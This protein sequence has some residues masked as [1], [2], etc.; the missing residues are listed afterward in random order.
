VFTKNRWWIHLLGLFAIGAAGVLFLGVQTYREAPPVA[1]FAAPDGEVLASAGRIREGQA[2]FQRYAL[3]EHGTMFGD[4]GCRGP[5]YSAEALHVS[6]LAMLEHHRAAAGGEAGEADVD[7]EEVLLA[8]VQGEIAANRHD[9]RTGTV[10]LAPSQVAAYEAVLESTR[11]KFAADGPE[12][13]R[14][15]AY[16]TDED[17]LAALGTFFFWSGW[18]C[19]TTRPGTDASYTQNWPY[20]PLVGNGPTSGAVL[21]SVVGSLAMLLATGVVLYR[22]GRPERSRRSAPGDVERLSTDVEVEREAPTAIQRAT[23]KYFAVAAAL[24]GLQVLSGILTVHDYVGFTTF[25]GHDLARALPITVVRS[26][27]V[28]LSILWIATCWIGGSIFLLPRISRREPKGQRACVEILFWMLVAVVAGTLFGTLAGP[29]GWLGESWRSLGHQGWEFV[30]LGRLWQVLLFAALV[31]WAVIV[32]RGVRPALRA[33]QPFSLPAWMLYSVAAI[34]ALFLS[35][36]VAPRDASFVVADFWRWMVIHMWAECFFEVFTTVIVA[37]FLVHMGLVG[38]EAATRVVFFAVLLFCGSG[39]LGISHNFYWNAKPE[40]TLAIGAV[41][42]TL[43][44]VPLI[45]LTLET[46]RL[47]RLPQEAMRELTDGGRSRFGHQAA[48]RFLVAVNFW[49]FLGAGVFGFIINL[50]IVNYYEHGTYLTVNHGHAALM[51]VYGNLSIAAILFCARWLVEPARWN[52]ALLTVAFWS[53]NAGLG[54]M[55]ALDLL[56]AGMLQL[57]AVLERGLWFARSQEWLLATPFQTLTWMRS[58]G[59]A[60]FVLGGVTPLVWFALSRWRSLRRVAPVR[61]ELR[62]ET[63]ALDEGNGRVPA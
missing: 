5:D 10:T 45:L 62:L 37:W 49:N 15:A 35:G 38:R 23:Y 61:D 13:F 7:D 14:P 30:E 26:W 32:A 43:Q 2:V 17:E 34:A 6:A 55:V 1:D 3:M 40:P 21:W 12:S 11:E 22:R 51:G 42:S 18:V 20:D 36:F 53:L 27:H 9:P 41:F 48:F 54:L 28:Q 33:A 8:R 63:L 59:G 31:L 50:P 4:G 52:D 56:P 60:L 16:I 57:L 46:W 58:V 29:R 47:R 44:V 39:L 25:F 24:F 19:G